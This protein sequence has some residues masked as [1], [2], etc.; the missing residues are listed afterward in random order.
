MSRLLLKFSLV[1][2]FVSSF[3]GCLCMSGGMGCGALTGGCNPPF[4]ECVGDGGPGGSLVT[5]IQQGRHQRQMARQARRGC[6]CGR[7]G[8]QTFPMQMAGGDYGFDNCSTCGDDGGYIDNGMGYPNQFVDNGM[9]PGM[10]SDGM[11]HGMNHGGNCPSCQ[12]QQ[13]MQSYPVPQEM[14]YHPMPNAPM[15][16]TSP[17]EPTP[18]P[19]TAPRDPAANGEYFAPPITSPKTSM[20]MQGMQ[21]MMTYGEMPQGM[22]AP[23]MMHQGMVQQNM[24]QSGMMQ[25]GMVSGGMMAPQMMQTQMVPQQQMMPQQMMQQ[26]M[27]PQMPVQQTQYYSNSSNTPPAVQAF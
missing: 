18:A 8:M 19:P 6:G 16:P 17:M 25:N 15:P 10:I 3:S 23:V 7:H 24:M 14:N 22:S 12:N 5:A 20:M 11:S 27:T 21:P 13:M 1:A 2:G 9:M 4:S 26:H